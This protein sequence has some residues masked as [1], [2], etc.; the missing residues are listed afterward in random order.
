MNPELQRLLLPLALYTALVLLVGLLATRGSGRS[1]E[2]YF[3]AGRRLGTVVLFMA[4]FGTNATAFVF[5]GAPGRAYHDGIGVFSVTAPIVALFTPL[6]FLFIGGPARRMA[7]RLGALTPAELY[8]RRLGSS[9][10]GV[11]MF[12]LFAAYTV[13]YMVSAVVGAA[14]TLQGMTA[15]A[16]PPWAGALAVVGIAL[17]Y[18]TL[19]GMRATAWTN[20]LQ[21]AIF[22]VFLVL[23][24]GLIAR[25]LGG[26]PEAVRTVHEREPQLLQ[27][28]GTGLYEPRQWTSWGL[29]ISMTVIAFPHM[30]VRLMAAGSE[31]AI[32]SVSRLYP[33]ALLVLW[34]PPVLIGIWGALEFPGL[35][36]RASDQIL[37][38]MVD[39]HLPPAL[40]SLGLI[41]VLAAVMSSLDAMMLTLASMLVRD[42]LD[43]VR[44]R[45]SERHD[46][47]LGRLFTLGVAVGV[48]ALAMVWSSSVFEIAAT[49]FAG[50]VTLT[51]TLLLG[52]RWRR[53]NA[54]GATA[55]LGV[56]TAV[57]FLGRGDLLPAFGFLP[58][59]WAFI[60]SM[61]AGV[62]VSLITAPPPEELTR[63]AFGDA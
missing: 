59:F 27:L 16:I 7:A 32:R 29:L 22:L 26:M 51:P 45:R 6:T 39:R 1:P 37:Q 50:F 47:V 23:V 4:L 63:L 62:V 55:S 48:Y 60:A 10:V 2:D 53:F 43:R 3:L 44:P 13:P 21:G 46:V 18:T 17:V 35:E 34:L 8:A 38:L 49:A 19:G 15:G 33:L 36:G 31:H 11:L 25:D 54:A 5:V 24:F 9:T 20:V 40:A 14:V 28:P 56:G 12:L 58:V 41:A 57:L 61:S 30:F 42:V 52:V